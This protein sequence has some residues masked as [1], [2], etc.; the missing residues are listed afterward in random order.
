MLHARVHI[1]SKLCWASQGYCQSIDYD[2]W[3]EARTSTLYCVDMNWSCNNIMILMLLQV[4][5]EKLKQAMVK[6][7]LATIN[8][9]LD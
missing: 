4:K 7:L 8:L 5:Q 6:A 1:L 9:R 3:L 2:L